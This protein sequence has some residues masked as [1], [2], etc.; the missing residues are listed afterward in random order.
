M[1]GLALPEP[2]IHDTP[3]QSSHVEMKRMKW[4][5]KHVMEIFYEQS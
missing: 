5:L 3:G 4:K 2:K 1:L